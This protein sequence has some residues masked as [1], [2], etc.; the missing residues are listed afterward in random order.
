MVNTTSDDGNIRM[1]NSRPSD[2]EG[3]RAVQ[4]CIVVGGAPLEVTRVWRQQQVRLPESRLQFFQ[5][6]YIVER[7]LGAGLLVLVSPLVLVLWCLVKLTSKGPGFYRQRR[8]GLNRKVFYVVKLRTMIFDAQPE[9]K[10]IRAC[11]N[12]RRITRVGKFL[13]KTHLDELPQLFN[14]A[15]GDMVLVGP[16]PE[17]PGICK[18]VLAP[19]IEG[20]YDR[21]KVK[22][23]I[24]G[25]SQINL[26]PDSAIEDAMQKQVLDLHY[27]NSTNGWLEFRI[28]LA[29]V[30]RV[31]GISGATV[32]SWMGLRRQRLLDSLEQPVQKVDV[33]QERKPSP[34]KS[35]YS[36]SSITP[37]LFRDRKTD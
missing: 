16:R 12:D 25:L 11:K 30:L 7:L 36:E 4:E 15:A 10:E 32:M 22:P 6:K 5:L 37:L 9:G 8:I 2:N 20:Y 21:V 23:G 19:A 29:T 26:E 17:Q 33:A 27:I 18:D 24:T 3:K 28:L 35:S 34:R 14:V 31:F 13:R 1:T